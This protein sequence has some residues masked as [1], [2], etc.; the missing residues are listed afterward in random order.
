MADVFTAAAIKHQI[1][2]LVGY[3]VGVGLANDQNLPFLRSGRDNG[4]EVT[5]PQ[6]EHV[7][8]ALRDR[9]YGEIYKYLAQERAYVVKMP[10]GALMQMRYMF[11][12]GALQRH[13]LAFFPS[14]HLE[15]FQNNPEVYLEDEVYADI[16]AKSIV[17]FPFR[18]DCDCRMETVMPI[19]HPCSHL[20][21]GQYKNCRIPVSAPITPYCFV[22]FVLRN[23]YHTAYAKYADGLPHFVDAFDE[24]IVPDERKLAYLQLPLSSS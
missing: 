22:S 15:E 13:N 24:T 20:T 3:L 2:E 16:V 8:V 5:F 14:P 12:E 17:P 6:A 1:D 21:L 23:F 19:E 7:S 9:P 18:F 10:D 4:V 11:F